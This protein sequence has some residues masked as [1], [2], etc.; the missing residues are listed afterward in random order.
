MHRFLQCLRVITFALLWSVATNAQTPSPES[1]QFQKEN[2]SF[3]YPAS[4]TLSDTS[5]DGIQ[6][7]TLSRGDKTTQIAVIVQRDPGISC[8][9]LGR[10]RTVTSNLVNRVAAQ[11]KAPIPVATNI[12]SISIGSLGVPVIE[13][14]GERNGKPVTAFVVGTI[15]KRWFVNLV[16][17]KLTDDQSSEPAWNQVRSTLQISDEAGLAASKPGKIDNGGIL[18]GNALK[19]AQPPYPA[20]A[21]SAHAS[22]VVRIEVEIDETGTVTLAC[23]ASGHRLLQAVS[24]D[25]AMRSKF[26]PRIKEGTAVKFNGVIQY[27]F[28]IE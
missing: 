14:H 2:L 12:S 26:P 18:N 6:F 13:V 16:Y 22:G 15:I 25:A 4:W 8:A 3:D 7:I 23:P 11:I 5:G 21:R 28:V 27:K 19:L 20:E 1:K 10:S 9:S 17:L 24:I